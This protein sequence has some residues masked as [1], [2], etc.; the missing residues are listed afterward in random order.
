MQVTVQYLRVKLSYLP[1]LIQGKTKDTC[2]GVTILYLTEQAGRLMF[3]HLCTQP[4]QPTLV[5]ININQKSSLA[6]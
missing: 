2:G 1:S 4:K 5:L 6:S 3:G